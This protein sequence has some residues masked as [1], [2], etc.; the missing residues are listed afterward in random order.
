VHRDEFNARWRASFSPHGMVSRSFA[1]YSVLG[2]LTVVLQLAWKHFLDDEGL[3]YKHCPVAD[4]H[5]EL[6]ADRA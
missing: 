5:P 2:S 6:G 4:I 1:K 3:E